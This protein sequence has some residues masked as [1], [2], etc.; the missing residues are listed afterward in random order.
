MLFLFVSQRQPDFNTWVKLLFLRTMVQTVLGT[1]NAELVNMFYMWPVFRFH[2][3]LVQDS[4]PIKI[5]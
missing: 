5:L 3:T 1:V 4:H 2:N